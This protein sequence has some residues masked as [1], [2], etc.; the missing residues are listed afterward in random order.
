MNPNRQ[1]EFRAATANITRNMHG[2]A[3]SF[4]RRCH[5][6]NTSKPEAGGKSYKIYKNGCL[7]QVF[8]CAGC[9]T[10]SRGPLTP[11]QKEM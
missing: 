6:C 8:I 4:N 10:A 3:A 1:Q 2:V 9:L 5:C 7:Q 11:A